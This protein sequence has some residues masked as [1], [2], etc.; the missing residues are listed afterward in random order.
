MAAQQASFGGDIAY[1]P[2]TEL[3]R[4]IESGGKTGVVRFSTELG[5][6]TVWF[7]DG[8]LLDAEMGD[9]RA[10]AAVYRLLGL[11]DGA[12]EVE[13][14]PVD[15]H[16]NIHQSV[17][18][19]MATR[20]RRASEWHRL[21]DRVPPL[22]SLLC[23]NAPMLELERAK[24][25]EADLDFLVLVD[26][27]KTLLEVIDDSGL[28]AV[29]ALSRI[30]GYYE[31]GLLAHPGDD[32]GPPST[33]RYPPASPIESR[34]ETATTSDIAGATP[35]DKHASD[36][37]IVPQPPPI[38]VGGP[39]R[40]ARHTAAFGSPVAYTGS[41]PPAPAPEEKTFPDA[42]PVPSLGTGSS[43]DS[44]PSS[45]G[46]PTNSTS[47][48]QGEEEPPKAALLLGRY[49]VL[50]RIARGGMGSVYLCRATGEGG[51]R[52]LFALKVLRRHLS[53]NERSVQMFLDEAKIASALHHPNVV[54]VVD[55]G[56]HEGQPY[57]VMD[58]VEGSSFADLLRENP[59]YRPPRLVVPI[60]LDALSGLA[61]A[62]SL[63][64]DDG[65]P[66]GL[67]HCDFSPQN[68]LVGKDGIARV[69]DFGIARAKNAMVD[70]GAVST[71]GKPA[72]LS[73]EQVQGK[74]V[75]E[76]SDIFSVGVL[77]WNA[78]TGQQLFDGPTPE[79]TM[80]N[81]LKRR[82]APPSQ[83]GL[84]PPPCLDRIV[85]KALERDPK[86]RYQSAEEMLMDLRESALHADLLGPSLEVAAWVRE[87][88]GRD[89]EA[90]RLSLLD[91]SLR[92]KGKTPAVLP[93]KKQAQ[94]RPRHEAVP[95]SEPP[96]EDMSR[97]IVLRRPRRKQVILAGA[98]AAAVLALISAIFWPDA[99]GRAFS[100]KDE[101][102]HWSHVARK[103]ADDA[104]PE[105]P[106]EALA[107]SESAGAQTPPREPATSGGS[108]V[109]KKTTET[110]ALDSARRRPAH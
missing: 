70:R 50:S 101:S 47:D 4:T 98:A 65:V 12:F 97:T 21:V 14:G 110:S 34:S 38:S 11:S 105:R 108:G 73:P 106:T 71:H 9:A 19:L 33:L 43:E 27:R 42:A 96:S 87:S 77:L 64:D 16:R 102:G 7:A 5:P 15:R 10:E 36:A 76:R 26:A 52:R 56:S 68:L 13:Y 25:T 53:S 92:A 1:V 3:L 79:A 94:P 67:A 89:L 63:S 100:V 75:D 104:A 84:N 54:G 80:E 22:D 72:Y 66:L 18:A 40:V 57:L 6:A 49:E 23:V 28:D 62:H 74:P 24:L 59:T 109:P 78:L 91:A 85:L 37:P 31:A 8:H 88:F 93:P 99:V 55:V 17:G 20:A 29:E 39:R 51:F 86:R 30:L 95:S 45:G 46:L 107:P 69:T 2:P 90:R 60:L 81:V 48:A 41:D 58:Y 83:V 103:Q 82:I 44:P 61:A 35:D 32:P